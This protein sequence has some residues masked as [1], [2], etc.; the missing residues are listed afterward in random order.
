MPAMV[1]TSVASVSEVWA[2][3]TWVCDEAIW[4]SSEAIWA[5][6]A[7]SL[8]SLANSA[9]SLAKVAWASASAAVREVPSMVA[10]AWPADTVWPTLAWLVAR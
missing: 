1:E 2:L 8:W 5:E 7:S 9:W 3:V 4:A 6:E 10:S